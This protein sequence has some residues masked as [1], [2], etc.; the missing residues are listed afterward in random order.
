[1]KAV[2]APNHLV[3]AQSIA[4]TYTSPIITCLQDDVVGIQLNYTGSPVGAL[5]IQGSLDQTN[6][7]ALPVSVNGGS[8]VLTIAI[9]GASSP[10]LIDMASG[11]LPYLRVV[12]TASSGSGTLDMFVT[13]KRIGD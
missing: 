8:A 3:V 9:P 13:S 2:S 7:A 1:M 10:I 12:Y 11:S 5:A 6:W 4:T